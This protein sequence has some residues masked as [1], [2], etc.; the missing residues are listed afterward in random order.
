MD[1]MKQVG[2]VL[3]RYGDANPNRPPETVD[4]DF[5]LFAQNAPPAAVSEGL[6]RGVPFRADAGVR[7]DGV[8][9]LR[10]RLRAR[11]GPRC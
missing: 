2:D 11:S 5:D 6:V 7:A 10:P 1:W 3:D 9:A 4:R 8:A